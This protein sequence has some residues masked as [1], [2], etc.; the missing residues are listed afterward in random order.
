MNAADQV[1]E[2]LVHGSPVM[3]T[4]DFR[5][6]QIQ[7]LLT[8]IAEQHAIVRAVGELLAQYLEGIAE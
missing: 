6:D 2:L 7:L 3:L 5:H 4:G 8:H 1:R